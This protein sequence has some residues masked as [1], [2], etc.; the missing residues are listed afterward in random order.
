[1]N[2]KV[3]LIGNINSGKKKNLLLQGNKSLKLGKFRGY[4]HKF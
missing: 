1:M 3:S 2:Q 4:S